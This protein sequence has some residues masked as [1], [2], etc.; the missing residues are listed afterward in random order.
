MYSAGYGLTL[1]GTQFSVLTPTIQARVSGSCATGSSIRA[2]AADGSVTCAT[3]SGGTGDI[4]AVYAGPGLTGGG[5]SGDVTMTVAFAGTGAA[6]TVARS[7][8][9][10][11]AAYVNEGQASSVTAGMLA[12]GAALAEVLDDDGTGSGLDA[13]L[14]DGQHASAFAVTNHNHLGQTWTGSN[15]PLVITGTFGPPDYASLVLGNTDFEGDVLRVQ[16]AGGIGVWVDSAGADGV[17]VH[18]AGAPSTTTISARSNGFEVAG[19]EGYGLYVG[20]SDQSGVWVGSA[21]RYGVEVDSAS[22]DGVYVDSAGYNGVSVRHAGSPSTANDS[23]ERNGFE[24][25][26]AEGHGLYVGRADLDGVH[27]VLTGDDG[28][29]VY[30]AGS[31]STTN[32][33]AASNGFEVA[34]AEGYGLYVGRADLSGVQ[35]NSAGNDGVRVDSA[36]WDGVYVGS[37]GNYGVRVN[38]AG[39]DGVEVYSAGWDGVDATS[40]SASYYG[41]RFRNI[42]AGGT[43][44]YARGGS[45]TAADLV[46]GGSSSSS[47]AGRIHSDP[48]YTSSDIYLVSNDAV[49]VELDNDNDE[50]G[51]FWIVNGVYTT[52]FSVNENGDMTAIGTKT[53]LVTTQDYGQRKLYAMESPQNWFEDFGSAQ[54]VN[55][56]ATVP[57]EPIF[58][59][60]VNL[61]E[62]YHVF[63]TPLGDCALYVSGKTPT[64]FSV[65]AMGGQ[66]C[67]IAFD[68]RIVAKRLGYEGLRLDPP[69]TGAGTK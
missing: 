38:S 6:T 11:D 54:L 2:V 35:V 21:G 30:R 42:A 27:V 51:N 16:S 56:Q 63:L 29:Y 64:L 33:S 68:Y 69:G 45:N 23:T 28:V 1:S 18:Q 59:Q 40:T 25:A 50:S 43:G 47:S 26:G 55:G 10:H 58:A 65:K 5:A 7:D 31:S 20:R 41:G 49:F 53:A 67:S 14:L 13:D 19:A 62:T 61:S 24:I 9:D 46:L 17:Y 12:D 34:G 44:L 37:A 8:H 60:T 32:V 66:T 48:Q 57:I 4:T 52:V 22:Y 39:F 36:G 15:N 3:V